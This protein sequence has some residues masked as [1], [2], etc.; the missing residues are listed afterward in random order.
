MCQHQECFLYWTHPQLRLWP[1]PQSSQSPIFSIDRILSIENFMPMTNNHFAAFRGNTEFP[2]YFKFY[3][4]TKFQCHVMSYEMSY[5]KFGW[6][7]IFGVYLA[8]INPG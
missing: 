6:K 7:N 4:C 8:K 3:F 2:I 5:L 1:T